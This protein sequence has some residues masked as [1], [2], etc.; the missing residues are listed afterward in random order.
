MNKMN[1]VTEQSSIHKF[2]LNVPAVAVVVIRKR[3]QEFT[4]EGE[5]GS[6]R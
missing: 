3:K 4:P 2:V 5:G 6:G 1:K